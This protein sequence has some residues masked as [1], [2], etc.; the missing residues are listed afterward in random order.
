M[1]QHRSLEIAKIELHPVVELLVVVSELSTSIR[2]RSKKYA[3][4]LCRKTDNGTIRYPGE[5]ILIAATQIYVYTCT[6]ITRVAAC[7]K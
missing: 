5:H 4:S 1:V 7:V 3:A 6:S 2:I